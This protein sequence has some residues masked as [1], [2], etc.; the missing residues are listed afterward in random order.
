MTQTDKIKRG[1]SGEA[2]IRVSLSAAKLWS[3]KLVNAGFGTVFDKLIVQPAGGWAVEIKTRKEPT[4][5]FNVKSITPNERRGLDAFAAKVGS[6]RAV[7]IGIWRPEDDPHGRAFVIPW[8]AVR[9]DVC[10]GRRGSIKMTDW[11]ELPKAGKGW[12]MSRFGGA[13]CGS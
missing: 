10:S 4:I 2:C 12:D 5:A 11:P 9:D 13:P 7:I 1:A 8:S 6:D 3:H